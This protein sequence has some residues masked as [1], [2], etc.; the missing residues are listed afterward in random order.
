MEYIIAFDDVEKLCIVVVTGQLKRPDDSIVLQQLAR[1]MYET[2]GCDR[3]LYDMRRAEIIGDRMDTFKAGTVPLDSDHKQI[4][5]Q[6]ALV[7]SGDL[8]DHKFLETAS[9]NRGYHVRV[10]NDMNQARAWL[11]S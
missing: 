11:H 2:R 5:Q 10:F 1:E 7:Y 8:T 6:V 9:I 4:K 3:L